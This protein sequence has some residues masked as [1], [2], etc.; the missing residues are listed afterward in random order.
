M[1]VS[2]KPLSKAAWI[3][4][5]AA[6]AAFMIYAGLKDGAFL[7]LDYVNL[8]VHEAG[9]LIFGV[10][11]PTLGVW[12]GTLLQIIFPTVFLV[13]FGRRG[14][15]AGAYFSAFWLGESLL[16]SSAYIRDARAMALPLVGGGEH[17]WNIILGRL[18]LLAS[19]AVLADA[20]RLAGWLALALSF[21]WFLD[22]GRKLSLRAGD[23]H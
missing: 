19:D 15:A 14:D 10:F 8:P 5:C 3:A 9:H 6:G 22:K 12:G 13:Y 21:L 2:W 18:G 17:D 16:Y 7:L 11:G 20:V 4:G 1:A 23:G